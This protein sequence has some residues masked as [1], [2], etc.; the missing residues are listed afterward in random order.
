MDMQIK[1]I[2]VLKTKFEEKLSKLE[3][4]LSYWEMNQIQ[5]RLPTQ[6]ASIHLSFGGNPKNNSI[7]LTEPTHS[8][9]NT[10]Q[11]KY[12]RVLELMDYIILD[13]IKQIK[14]SITSLE[15][16]Y[17]SDIMNELLEVE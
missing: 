7:E 3:V 14:R 1:S 5:M 16:K 17:K 9:R 4:K 15:S 10:K 2:A 11:Q 8:Y 6:S 13:E 12:S